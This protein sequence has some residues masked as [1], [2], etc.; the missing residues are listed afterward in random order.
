MSLMDYFD[1]INWKGNLLFNILT[2][3]FDMEYSTHISEFSLKK[4]VE[5]VT[6]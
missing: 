2:N 1:S 6:L 5:T 3:I 4:I